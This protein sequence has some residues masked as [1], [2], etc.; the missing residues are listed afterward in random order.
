MLWAVRLFGC[1][2]KEENTLS[3]DIAHDGTWA[4]QLEATSR[5]PGTGATCS[6]WRV[7]LRALQTATGLLNRLNNWLEDWDA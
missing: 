2:A 4:E 7:L 6:S 1:R 3:T 5:A